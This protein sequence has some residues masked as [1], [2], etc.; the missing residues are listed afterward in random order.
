M[1]ITTPHDRF[2]RETFGRREIATDFLACYLPTEIRV[3]VDLTGLAISKD[4]YVTKELA[5][6]YSDLVYRMPYRDGTLDVYLL[7][8][9][10]SAP[11]RWTQ[12]QILRYIVLGGEQYL[13]QHPKARQLPPVYPLVLYHGEKLWRVPHEFQDLVRPLPAAI[14]PYVPQFRYDLHDISPRSTREIK[15]EILTR[16]VLLAMRHIH[17]DQPVAQLKSLLGLI[18]Q[19]LERPTALEI[20]EALLRYYVQGT[21]RLD[22]SDL[23]A[24]LQE[25]PAGERLMQTFIDKYIEQG[26]QEGWQKGS[27]EGWQKGSQ[28]GWQKGSQDGWQKGRQEGEA[29][30]LLRLVERR[31]GPPSEAVRQRIRD[32]DA[33]TLLIWAERLFTADSLEELFH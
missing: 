24:L 2:F 27:Q 19:V 16:L 31:F 7:F 10:K 28:E 30:V 13:K 4:T 8:Q 32:A 23:R 21:E 12:F 6:S 26:R 22:E 29:A 18:A 1:S 33:E 9:H 14:K 17:T 3:E 20:L 25:I 15:G 11:E 5:A